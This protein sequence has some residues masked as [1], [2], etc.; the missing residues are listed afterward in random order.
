MKKLLAVL[1]LI[2]AMAAGVAWVLVQ[3][4]DQPFQGYTGGDVLVSIPPGSS[5][6]TIG[7]SLVDAG[8]VRDDLTYRLTLWLTDDAR[9]LKAGD[10]R[11]DRPMTPR[12]VLGKIARGD[13][14]N[15]LVTFREGLTIAEMAVIAEEHGIGTSAEFVQAGQNASLVADLDPQARDLEGYL[16]PDTYAV[17]HRT[18]AAALIAL[19]VERFR[20]VLTADLVRAAADEGFTVRQLT[21]LASLVEKETGKADE[22]PIVAAVYRNRLK[23]PMLL[24]CD[25]T[26]IYALQRVGRY[27]GNIHRADIPF[28]SPY[29][30]YRYPGLPPG[31]IAAPGKASIDAAAHPAAVDYLYFVSKNDGSHAFS[32]TLTEHNRNVQQYQID[33]FRAQRKAQ[34]Q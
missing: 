9:R 12:D 3:R 24:Q 26:L 19:M 1:V 21:T 31:P 30:T 20:A 2:V 33:Y 22:R 17:P 28:D 11:F 13:V 25:P 14:D 6:H 29:N 18:D 34:G 15:V 7:Q 10:Y 23:Q 4:V 8:V 32:R 27:D 16:F 5:T